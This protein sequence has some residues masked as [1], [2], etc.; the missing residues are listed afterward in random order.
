MFYP[1]NTYVNR[2]SPRH[3]PVYTL[4]PLVNKYPWWAEFMRRWLRGSSIQSLTD[5]PWITGLLLTGATATVSTL[6]TVV[7]HPKTPMSAGNGGLRRGFPCLPSKDSIRAWSTQHVTKWAFCSV[8]VLPLCVCVHVCVYVHMCV[9]VLACV[10]AWRSCCVCAYVCVCICAYVCACFHA[11]VCAYTS[12]VCVRVCQHVCAYT[13]SVSV[14]VHV[15][16]WVLCTCVCVCALVYI[17][18][19]T[20]ACMCVHM[21]VYVCVCMNAHDVHISFSIVKCIF[22]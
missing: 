17:Y 16:T 19:C 7:G 4:M 5:L 9:C 21:C 12:S 13:S 22:P 1:F 6:A 8:M 18:Q 10:C 15:C 20:C 14:C 2:T 11:C 3:I